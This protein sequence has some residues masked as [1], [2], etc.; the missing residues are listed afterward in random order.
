MSMKPPPQNTGV[1]LARPRPAN[2]NAARLT[3]SPEAAKSLAG[4][5][6][7]P[8][9]ALLDALADRL[10]ERLWTRA[11]LPQHPEHASARDNP[12]G[13]ARAFLDAGRRGDFPTFKRGREVVA[14][15]ADVLAYIERRT[16][17]RNDRPSLAPP[18]PPPTAPRA[19]SPRR[20]TPQSPDERRRE[21]LRTA[22]ILPPG[23]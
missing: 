6:D 12:L 9:G 2:L 14:R 23:R 7:L 19:P 20:A 17:E 13:T 18:Q 21:Q 8:L 16:I 3:S 15:W 11:A 5:A 22:G 4:V 1:T 10:A